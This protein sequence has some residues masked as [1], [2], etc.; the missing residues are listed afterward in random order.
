M[1]DRVFDIKQR[2]RPSKNSGLRD[3]FVKARVSP[4][5][6]AQLVCASERDG[7]MLSE[8]VRD[9]LLASSTDQVSMRALFTEVTA[10]RLLLNRVLRV[11]T[12]GGTMTA[13][14]FD[15]FV[16]SLR[17]DKHT[18]AAEVLTQYNDPLGRQQA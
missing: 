11:L 6:L 18:S 1:A 15:G 7:Q 9:T 17:V 10:T 5:E 2:L 4:A 16:K 12:T 8:W 13:A 3:K 14:E